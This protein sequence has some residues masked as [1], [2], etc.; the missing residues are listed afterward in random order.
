MKDIIG[1]RREDKNRWERRVPLI[2]SHVKELIA[3]HSL[4]VI[5]QPSPLRILPDE[6]YIQEGALIQEDLS[7][8]RVIFA[9]K[10]IPLPFFQEDKVYVFFSHTIKG[11]SDNMPMLKKMMELGC[12]LI[13]Y[14][15]IVDE[16]G[17]RLVFFGSQAGQAGM[18]DTLWGLGQRLNWEGQDNPFAGIRQAYQYNSLVEAK[19]DIQKVGWTIHEKGLDS[20]L[21]PFV[22][23]FAGYGRVSQGAQDIFDLLPFE[24]VLPEDLGVLIQSK[25]YTSNKLYKVVFEEKHMVEPKSK[26][27]SFELQDYYDS[28]EKYIS[29]FDR[30]LEA[31]TILV[32]CIYWAP[33]YPRLVTKKQLQTLWDQASPPRLKIIGDISCDVEGSVECT[34]RPTSPDQPVFVYDPIDKGARDGIEGRGVVVM[35]IDNLPAEMPLESSVFFSQSLK[36]LVPS[37]LKGDFSAEFE[38]CRLPR[39]IRNAVILYHGGL[40]PDYQ[41]LNEFI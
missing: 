9:I 39:P 28:P 11:Q 4:S 25:K 32:N 7:S 3:E 29:V 20:S 27:D 21:V 22:C 26:N 23:G 2:P 18:I 8:C 14:E 31:L 38:H 19:E 24:E 17:Q 12:T 41:Y 35:A 36:P 15:K 33:Q 5:L 16:N 1:I 40:T 37:I 6:E 13:D 34:L 10:E 30:Y